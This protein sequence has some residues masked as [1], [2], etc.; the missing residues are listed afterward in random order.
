MLGIH[1]VV[2]DRRIEPEPVAIGLTVVEGS[3]EVFAAAA[4]TTTA[5]PAAP[6]R[7]LAVV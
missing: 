2:F 1:G 5:A 4:A 3:L 6:F 7:P